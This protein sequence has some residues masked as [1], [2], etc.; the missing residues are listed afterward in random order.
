MQNLDRI[1]KLLQATNE[2]NELT[3][4][5]KQYQF[6]REE[7][8]TLF[9]HAFHS[10]ITCTFNDDSNRDIEIGVHLSVDIGWRVHVEQDENGIYVIVHRRDIGAMGHGSIQLS[11]PQDTHLSL[12]LVECQITFENLS[13]DFQF[14][15]NQFLKPNNYHK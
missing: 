8:T 3:Q 11:M 10:D 2:L 13:G 6:I 5:R 9:V 1:L 4:T 15:G 14:D 7:P 12:R